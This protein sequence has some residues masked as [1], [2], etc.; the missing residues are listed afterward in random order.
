MYLGD[1]ECFTVFVYLMLITT[2]WSRYYYCLHESQR[3][4]FVCNLSRVTE[5]VSAKSGFK[6][7]NLTPKPVILNTAQSA[8]RFKRIL[9][10]FRGRR[11]HFQVGLLRKALCRRWGFSY[12]GFSGRAGP[13]V[14]SLI[15]LCSAWP[16][17]HQTHGIQYDLDGCARCGLHPRWAGKTFEYHTWLSNWT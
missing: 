13:M 9:E 17:A 4:E 15:M 8:V 7:S 5:L 1:F 12:F 16:G 6:P 2:I 11:N 10:D 14:A 3:Y